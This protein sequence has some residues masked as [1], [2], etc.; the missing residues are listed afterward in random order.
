MKW[1]DVPVPAGRTLQSSSKMYSEMMK[2]SAAVAMTNG[3]DITPSKKR[4]RKNAAA[5]D[6]EFDGAATPKKKTRVRKSKVKAVSPVEDDEEEGEVEGP[7]QKKVKVE[8]KDE[9]EWG[10]H[11]M[12]G[13]AERS[14]SSE[15]A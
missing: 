9:K 11:G 1:A 14:S 7:S 6:D 4:G 2:A 10:E 3:A 8:A 15:L 12:N 13:D 5:V